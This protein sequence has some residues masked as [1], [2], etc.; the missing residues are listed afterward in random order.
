[1]WIIGCLSRKGGT[2]GR[3]IYHLEKRPCLG[4]GYECYGMA[5]VGDPR[6]FDAVARMNPDFIRKKRQRLTSLVG[7]LSPHGS[8]PRLWCGLWCGLWLGSRVCA[9]PQHMRNG[10]DSKK[11]HPKQGGGN[12]SGY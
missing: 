5:L 10:Q 9:S 4:V 12:Q 6:P 7:T 11:Q 3:T 2:V 1:L 8:A